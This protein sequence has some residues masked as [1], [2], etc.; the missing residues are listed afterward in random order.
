[1]SLGSEPSGRAVAW[2]DRM[3]RRLALFGGAVL[4]ALML[5]TV[6]DVTL[7]KLANAPI[8]GGQDIAQ[9]A[10]LVVVAFTM[11]YGGRTG[12]H[13]SVDLLGAVAGPAVTRWTDLVVKAAG[14]VMLSV[15]VWRCMVNGLNA[16]DYGEASNLLNIPFLPF[17]M[18]LALGFA[19]YVIVLIVEFAVALAGPAGGEGSEAGRATL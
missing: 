8:F 9:V 7:R 3:A 14:A 2:V 15:L 12:A 16:A 13:V 6:V 17:Y 19:A 11:A 4:I 1:M 18:S 5:L 10:L